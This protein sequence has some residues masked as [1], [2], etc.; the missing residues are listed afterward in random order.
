MHKP[1]EDTSGL[2]FHALACGCAGCAAAA[3][4][5]K[6]GSAVHS[7]STSSQGNLT[8]IA[9]PSNDV[10][11]DGTINPG[12][13]DF[14]GFNL[15]AGQTYMFS[16]YGSGATPL[17]DTF[18]YVL[19][20]GFGLLNFDDDGGAGVNSLVTYTATYTGLHIIGVEGFSA[21]QTGGY[22]LDALLQ[23]PTDIVGDTFA[24]APSL[25]I[26][27]VAYGFIDAGPDGPYGP[28][29][30][31]VDTYSFTAEAG[32]FYSFEIAGGADYNS[33]IFNLPAGELDTV[34]AI[35][36][37]DGNLVALN[38]D[39]NFFGGDLGSRVG[40]FAEESGTYYL[41]V[42]SY[43]PYSGGF[44]ITSSEINPADYDPL[45]SINWVS[46]N[47][48][49]FDECNTAYVYFAEAGNDF[50]EGLPS[51]GWTDFEKQQVMKA[52]EEYEKV[53]GVNYE[54]TTDESAA[55][56]RLFTTTSA[57]FGAYMYPQD[58]AFGDAQGIAAFNVDSGGWGAFPQSLEQGGYSFE[59]ILHEFGHGHGLAHPHDNGGGSEIM[60]GVTAA[61][62]S[63]GIYDLNQG[64]YTVMSYNSSWETGPNGE[65]PFTIAGVSNGWAGTLSAFDIAM[66]QERYGA[67]NHYAEGNDTYTI[68]DVQA[69]GTYYET[70]W[71]TKG[72]DT[73]RYDGARNA[74]IDL[75]AATLNYSPTG[76]GVVS[77]VDGIWGGFT[78]AAG[79]VIE[80]ARGGSG[81]DVLIGNSAKNE[82]YGNAG[83]DFLMGRAGGDK[84]DGGADF[85]TAS[86]QGSG[87]AV[88]VSLA[89]GSGSGGDAAGDCLTN[90]EAVEGSAFNDTL[91]GNSGNNTLTGG[92]G[93]DKLDGGSGNDTLDGGDGNDTLYGGNGIDALSGGDGDDKLDGGNDNDSL[94][95]GA[96]ND[97][98]T[99]G[100]GI[101]T[102]D[103]GIGND[104][105]TG[106]NARDHFVFAFGDGQD[107]ITDFKK[108]TDLIDLR[109]TDLVWSDLDSN[110]NNKLDDADLYVSVASGDTF[111]D[112]GLANGGV[113]GVDV[114]RI[115][116]VTN[117]TKDSFLF[118]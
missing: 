68:K 56:F 36:D 106:G 18:L 16:V 6:D 88:N 84:L 113:G 100:N 71:D 3:S 96:G 91:T 65:S 45:D 79:V 50:G 54:I 49:Q 35:Y 2:T 94:S 87:A 37:G 117:L 32:M 81:D 75:T 33:D 1:Q 34:I 78:I 83:D 19:N 112:L 52:L 89:S 82:L 64:V 42:F 70:I 80:N 17:P 61:Q 43:Q 29:F 8:T 118:G 77:F 44:S 13:T 4:S 24:G 86:Y 92:D 53:L 51:F 23:P 46:A 103:G 40:F 111:I 60:L 26:G 39:I 9:A 73:I 38:D 20:G 66:L 55:T 97:K 102:L 72:K 99:G 48:V 108:N 109:P 22:T 63:Y 116:D 25:T 27:T 58:P 21:S 47:N 67:N 31:E 62:G 115:D 98:L 90:I 30:G 101:D 7:P 12:E 104:T 41:D 76:G 110:A 107:R 5:G 57:S 59:T 14:F 11:I 85:D 69:V 10:A 74:R 93:N 28:G 95:G 105:L 114:V 15:V